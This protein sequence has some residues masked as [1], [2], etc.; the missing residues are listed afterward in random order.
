ML[1]NCIF[2]MYCHL[3]FLLGIGYIK[4]FPYTFLI[5]LVNKYCY[6]L[7]IFYSVCCCIIFWFV[8]YLVYWSVFSR[9]VIFIER[10]C[11]VISSF[12]FNKVVSTIHLYILSNRWLWRRV[13][14]VGEICRYMHFVEIIIHHTVHRLTLQWLWSFILTAGAT[15][16]NRRAVN[17]QSKKK[18]LK[19]SSKPGQGLYTN[20]LGLN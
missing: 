11:L 12:G 2:D 5:L 15:A 4:M 16:K 13:V 8:L 3:V 7:L 18:N 14:R 6:F 19:C 17:L 10:Q 1:I 9:F 20:L